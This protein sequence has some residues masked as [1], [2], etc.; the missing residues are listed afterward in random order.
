MMTFTDIWSIQ[1][2]PVDGAV[3]AADGFRI[4]VLTDRLLRLEYEP[5][6]RF[7][8]GATA[9]VI[10]RRFPLP[11]FEVRRGADRLTVETRGVR[12]EYDM[13][14]FSPAGLTAVMKNAYLNHGSVWPTANRS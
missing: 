6:N 12:L 2:R 11:E 3:I 7:R 13:K 1:P 5:N 9:T 4:T 10:N 8:D 14:P